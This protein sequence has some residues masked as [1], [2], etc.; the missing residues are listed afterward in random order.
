MEPS[1]KKKR[2]NHDEIFSILNFH[3]ANEIKNFVEEMS[4]EQFLKRVIQ[5][6]KQESKQT[7]GELNSSNERFSSVR[8]ARNLNQNMPIDFLWK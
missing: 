2:S 8:D 6:S 7:R 3:D 5:D 4:T 1:Q